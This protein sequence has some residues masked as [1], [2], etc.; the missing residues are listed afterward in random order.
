MARPRARW[1]QKSLWWLRSMAVAM[2]NNA[3]ASRARV[4]EAV[5]SRHAMRAD[6]WFLVRDGYQGRG[7]RSCTTI[8]SFPDAGFPVASPSILGGDVS[9]WV[10]GVQ[11]F[12]PLAG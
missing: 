2:N 9:C 12:S 3:G 11:W 7:G 8:S 6:I 10:G 4:Q 5:G 1:C